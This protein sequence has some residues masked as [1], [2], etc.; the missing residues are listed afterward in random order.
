MRRG[1]R[2]AFTLV[3]LL[4]VIAIIG[5]LIALLLP[6]V[7]AA[8]EAARR[9]S[10]ANN[11]TQIMLAVQ[12]YNMAHRVYPSGTVNPKGPI[13]NLPEGYHHNWI[14]QILPYLEQLSTYRHINFGVGVYDPANEKVRQVYLS[15][16]QCPSSPH[17]TG[18]LGASSYAGCHND[19]ETPID[20]NNNG[21]FFLNRPLDYT[22]IAD[23]VSQTIFVGEKIIEREETLGWMSGTRSTL[24]NT[25]LRI[26]AGVDW[27]QGRQGVATPAAPS[28]GGNLWVGNFASF[29][30][31]GAQFGFGDGHVM[32]LSDSLDLEVLQQLA[33]RADGKL[34]MGNS[35]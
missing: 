28:T 8:R 18:K 5:I 2:K 12:N 9:I 21:V 16:L 14:S 13:A 3:E 34:L 15:P 33:N 25:G 19:A 29:H 6:A 20:V 35:F 31:G 23:G 24:R 10:C 30:P 26:N 11:L 7:Q 32:F 4:V 17:N 27:R 22:E 1:S